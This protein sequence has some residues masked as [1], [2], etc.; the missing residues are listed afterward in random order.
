MRQTTLGASQRRWTPRSK[1]QERDEA[2]WN[3]KE[4]ERERERR[5]EK[6]PRERA[7]KVS[8]ILIS[9][10]WCDVYLTTRGWLRRSREHLRLSFSSPVA[11]IPREMFYS[12]TPR[13]SARAETSCCPSSSRL[14]A[15]AQVAATAICIQS[16]LI[17]LSRGKRKDERGTHSPRTPSP[18][19]R[20]VYPLDNSYWRVLLQLSVF[21][22]R[23]A[24]TV[25]NLWWKKSKLAPLL[26]KKI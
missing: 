10:S 19:S 20:R 15:L 1:G 13:A 8:L 21:E 25:Q 24:S 17:R 22:A 7:A 26:P 2:S 9:I 6:E 12:G 5:G 4:R 23:H 18:S 14:N 11:E 3:E 16:A